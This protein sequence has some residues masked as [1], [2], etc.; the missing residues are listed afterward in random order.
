MESLHYMSVLQVS[1][2]AHALADAHRHACVQRHFSPRPHSLQPIMLTS[3]VNSTSGATLDM[4]HYPKCAAP[5]ISRVLSFHSLHA[6]QVRLLQ[7]DC[8]VAGGACASKN[9]T[10]NPFLKHLTRSTRTL[11]R[12]QVRCSLQCVIVCSHRLQISLAGSWQSTFIAITSCNQIKEQ[13]LN[14]CT[15]CD[16]P[17]HHNRSSV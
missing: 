14:W 4:H 13:M 7:E 16:I 11:Y 3:C 17:Q 5:G 1:A 9:P 6:G 10:L 2:H 8:R 12:V 15:E